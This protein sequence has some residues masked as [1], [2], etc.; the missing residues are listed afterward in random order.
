MNRNN[1]AKLEQAKRVLRLKRSRTTIW[2]GGKRTFIYRLL[3]SLIS[4]S[5]SSKAKA[6]GGEKNRV[7]LHAPKWFRFQ[8][9]KPNKHFVSDYFSFPLF[10]LRSQRSE[11]MEVVGELKRSWN[12]STRYSSAGSDQRRVNL[13]LTCA[14]SAQQLNALPRYRTTN[15]WIKGNQRDP[16]IS[17]LHAPALPLH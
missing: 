4:T 10:N 9:N 2:G 8:L 13:S 11:R 5:C 15:K 16:E 12:C 6:D 17:L 14:C 3:E 1:K 7:L